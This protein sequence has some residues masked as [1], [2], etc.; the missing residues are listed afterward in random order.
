[1]EQSGAGRAGFLLPLLATIAAMAAFQAG[2]AV[3]KALFPALGPQGTAALRVT[4]GALMLAALVRPWRNWPAAAP[5]GGLLGLGV[6]VAAAILC[7]FQA[8]SYL[9]L[10]VALPLQFIGPLAVAVATSRRWTDVV[11]TA[12]AALGVWALVG[13]G[14]SAA[15]LDIRGI[16]WALAA[17]AGW[18]AYIVYGRS[19]G[20]AFGAAAAPV[21]L[22]IAAVVLL[23]MGVA[24]AGAE[25][26]N[27]VHLP[28]ALGIGLLAGVI[29]FGLELYAMPRM[30]ARTFATLMA[31]EPAFSVIAGL[32]L[33][34]ERLATVQIAGVAAVVVAAAG[35]AWSGAGRETA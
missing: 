2:A 5:L 11:W 28:L 22:G 15:H 14:Q 20:T 32:I 35:A 33:L 16:A 10:G 26:F 19:A 6:S 25:L 13:A 21:S 31:L 27:P 9:P 18:A 3:S 30:P 1:M 17:A 34:G 23:P 8:I 7:F 12:F 29:P 4:F 24:H